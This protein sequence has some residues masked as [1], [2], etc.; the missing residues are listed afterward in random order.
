MRK[1]DRVRPEEWILHTGTI[2]PVGTERIIL[3]P[4]SDSPSDRIQLYIFPTIKQIEIAIY[5]ITFESILKKVA[6]ISVFF[7]EIEEVGQI[8]SHHKTGKRLW[9]SGLK[10][11]M[12]MIIHQTIMVKIN[13]V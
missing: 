10:Q 5:D 4:S 8:N 11:K 9:S 12:K 1:V 2:E 6:N 7:S 13:F 3:R